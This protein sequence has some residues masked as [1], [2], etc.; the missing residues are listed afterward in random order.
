MIENNGK[1]CIDYSWLG[2][3][4]SASHRRQQLKQLKRWVG[5]TPPP[6]QTTQ[7]LGRRHTAA[8]NSNV[9]IH[10]NRIPAIARVQQHVLVGFALAAGLSL[11]LM[12]LSLSHTACYTLACYTHAVSVALCCTLYVFAGNS[13]RGVA[14]KHYG[15]AVLAA[16]RLGC[17]QLQRYW[18]CAPWQV[19]H[20]SLERAHGLPAAPYDMFSVVYCTP[21]C[22]GRCLLGR[23]ERV[24]PRGI[25]ERVTTP[26]ASASAITIP[27]LLFLLLLLLLLL[28]SF[29]GFYIIFTV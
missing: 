28:F 20:R 23:K 8:N 25:R 3:V 22:A 4:G 5:V 12:S 13:K 27:L 19:V 16:V 11:S 2:R 29:L 15:F 14:Q 26:P 9:G 24:R 1:P 10:P 21:K 6:T 18:Q 7:T 17:P